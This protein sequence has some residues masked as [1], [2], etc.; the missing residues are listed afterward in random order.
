M[1]LKFGP[2]SIDV[3]GRAEA[4]RAKAGKGI[5]ETYLR[6]G[7]VSKQKLKEA[8]FSLTDKDEHIRAVKLALII[9]VESLLVGSPQKNNLVLAPELRPTVEEVEIEVVRSIN[10]NDIHIKDKALWS[11][12]T[13]KTMENDERNKEKVKQYREE[14]NASLHE[15]VKQHRE[16]INSSLQEKVKQHREEIN[17]SLQDLVKQLREEIN[18]SLQE[19]VNQLREEINASLQEQVKKIR[20]DINSSLQELVKQLKEE[21]QGMKDNVPSTSPLIVENASLLE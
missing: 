12:P 21:I 10:V 15:Q 13:A 6:A 5:R 20:E 2:L 8:Y 7:G 19:Q 11:A 17:A 9:C 1:G 3:G 14:I 4:G 18:A 16:E